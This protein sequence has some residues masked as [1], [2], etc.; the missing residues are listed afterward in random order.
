[1]AAQQ[2]NYSFK[3]GVNKGERF[4][5]SCVLDEEV[6]SFHLKLKPKAS[7]SLSSQRPTVK[8]FLLRINRLSKNKR[9]FFV[10][11]NGFAKVLLKCG[12]QLHILELATRFYQSAMDTPAGTPR[13]KNS[14]C[15]EQIEKKNKEGKQELTATS[16]SNLNFNKEAKVKEKMLV[17]VK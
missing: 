15:L 7:V 6:C 9:Y 10:K 17:R 3:K 1:M 11:T 2:C 12:D 16:S 14:I 13:S 5:N 8:P 4:V